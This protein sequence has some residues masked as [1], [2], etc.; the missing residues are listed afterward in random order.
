MQFEKVNVHTTW[1]DKNFFCTLS[2]QNLFWLLKIAN[3]IAWMQSIKKYPSCYFEK[4]EAFIQEQMGK[5]AKAIAASCL[6]TGFCILPFIIRFLIL[7]S[8]SFIPVWSYSS[9]I[10]STVWILFKESKFFLQYKYLKLKPVYFLIRK[11]KCS[12]LTILG[13]I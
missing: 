4:R 6:Q 8:L 1:N 7:L 2:S 13:F 12:F 3:C 9:T 11:K 5:G 10:S